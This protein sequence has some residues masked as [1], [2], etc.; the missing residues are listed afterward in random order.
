MMYRTFF[1]VSACESFA[2]NPWKTNCEVVEW[3]QS[4]HGFTSQVFVAIAVRRGLGVSA[5]FISAQELSSFVK[6]LVLGVTGD[7]VA[8][9]NVG[10]HFIRPA[11][12]DSGSLSQ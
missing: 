11:V 5:A 7:R 12:C 3:L 4:F 8:V 6:Q 2:L 9:I 1:V 10:H